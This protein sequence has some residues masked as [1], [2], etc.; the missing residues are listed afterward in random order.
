MKAKHIAR[1]ISAALMVLAL[2]GCGGG[3]DDA[4]P[5][6]TAVQ[7]GR[8]SAL[9][10]AGNVVSA[11]PMSA[12]APVHVVLV[13][14][15]ND[16]AGLSHF[17][18]EARTPGS[19]SFGAV[20]TAAQI[21][22]R[23]APTA[24]QVTSVKAYLGSSGFTNIKVADNNMIV[25]ADAPAGVISG[26]FQTTLV[27]VAMADGTST[28]INTVP[29]TVPDAIGGVVQG[30]LGLDTATRLR[31]NFVRASNAAAAP[32]ANASPTT[33]AVA[34]GHNPTDF[35]RIYSVGSAPAA[36][37]T[38][39]G[40]I[41]EG[42]VT[43]SVIDLSTFES[44]NQL[45]AVPVSVI[46]AGLSSAD[47]SATTEWSLDSQTIVGMSGGLKQLNFYVARSF[48]WGDMALAINR[49]VTD[50]TARVINM[51]IG[52][53]ENWAPT[54]VIDTLFQ[55]AVAQ[56]QTFSVSSG[57]SGSVAYG[58]S[59]TSVQYPATSPYVVAVG[60]TT[61]YTN[62]N[63]S[64]AGEAAWDSS[65]GGISGIEPIPSWQS[66][67]PAL[68]GRTFRGMPDI[69]FDADPNSGEAVVAGGQLVTLGGT[70]LSAPLFAATWARMLSGACATN[71]GFAAPT[72]Y[73]AQ[74]KTPSVFRDITYGS[75]G[76]YSA[77]S[78][79]DFVT[80]WGTPNVSAMYSAICVP[81]AAIYGGVINQGTTLRP[82]QIVYSGSGSHQLAM[83][84]DGN[85]VLYNTT[86]G[87]AVWNSGTYG[88]PGAYAVFQGDGNFVV[89]DASGKALWNSATSSTSYS[90]FLAVQD[91]GNLV[92]Y[93]SFVPVFATSTASGVY[94]NSTTGPA[95]WKG[96]VALGSGQSFTSGNG[97]NV[98]V[99]QGDGN[100][101]LLR[102]GVAQW[103]SG[104]YGHP[105]AFAAMQADGNLVVYSSTGVPLWYS[106][107]S[108]NSGAATYVQDDGNVVIY[109]PLPRWSTNTAGA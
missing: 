34:V 105:G 24:Q 95:V 32:T 43:Q 3:D 39:V 83:Q 47:T 87:A 48:A 55:L 13:L 56:G 74:A 64:Y 19:A 30:V 92:I 76:A 59:G 54:A 41:A 15:L 98:L 17:L 104:T 45:P 27:P 94:A 29:E 101:V 96:G 60:G 20:L 63:G 53:C 11:A 73:S 4:S 90:Q 67:V 85:L 46:H 91:D 77:G 102:Q 5:S 10:A 65:G 38:T 71:L 33:S 75:N 8:L 81:T 70:S 42:D 1:G 52:G 86:N 84:N 89:Y 40:I 6:V 25:E 14:K 107:T 26:V 12:T 100:L 99:M 31:P 35:P 9:R 44:N 108:G 80:G 62:G 50:N 18:Q 93:R 79:W 97:A 23:Y 68:K 2:A 49:A 36:V 7:T 109:A 16:A 58:C 78:G 88:N 66:N 103:S 57:D 82:G 22:A 37:N 106:D 61:L 21:A 69:A 28:H 51:S 72:L